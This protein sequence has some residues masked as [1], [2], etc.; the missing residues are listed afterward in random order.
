VDRKADIVK[1]INAFLQLFVVNVPK[2]YN[3]TRGIR[4]S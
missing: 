1:L 2:A 4:S 3:E